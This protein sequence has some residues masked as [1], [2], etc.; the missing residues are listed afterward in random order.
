MDILANP[1]TQLDTFMQCSLKKSVTEKSSQLC[2]IWGE[3][4]YKLAW[5]DHLKSLFNQ[6]LI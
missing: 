6:S 2:I 3:V 4:L 5:R 1:S